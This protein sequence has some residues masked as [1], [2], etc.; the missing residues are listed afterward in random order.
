MVPALAFAAT[1]E[2]PIFP[3]IVVASPW[4]LLGWNVVVAVPVES[5]VAVDGEKL[6]TVL[7]PYPG[8]LNT[9]GTPA[10]A[11][12]MTAVSVRAEDPAT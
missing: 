9:T 6:Y 12:E 11:G 7:A 5:V 1:L 3:L 8:A 4:W 10:C 2:V